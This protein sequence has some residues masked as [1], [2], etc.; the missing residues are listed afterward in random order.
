[1]LNTNSNY[2]PDYS[3]YSIS[4]LEDALKHIDKDEYPD[5]V[6]LIEK[7]L[8]NKRAELTDNL[9]DK[10]EETLT[11]NSD[12]SYK[13]IVLI[14][15]FFIIGG[16]IKIIYVLYKY[17]NSQASNYIL[18]MYLLFFGFA[19]FAGLLFFKNKKLGAYFLSVVSILQIPILNI[20]SIAWLYSV[21]FTSLVYIDTEFT[22]KFIFG[23]GSTLSVGFFPDREPMFELGFNI[24]PI[25]FS[26]L[27]IKY[28]NNFSSNRNQS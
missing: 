27:I 10:K 9:I 13:P 8:L 24:I 20:G 7:E 6:I 15:L 22:F 26:I 12:W 23:L 21:F 2:I 4:E 19:V 28:I 17:F 5:R 16:M 11:G 25:I 18:F 1:M 3:N 14:S